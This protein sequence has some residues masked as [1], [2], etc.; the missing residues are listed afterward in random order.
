MTTRPTVSGVDE[1]LDKG[2]SPTKNRKKK[3]LSL[4]EPKNFLG[5]I[6]INDE[7]FADDLILEEWGQE[8]EPATR[9]SS[10]K[11]VFLAVSLNLQESNRDRVSF[12]IQLQTPG[13]QIFT[14]F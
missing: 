5:G 6:C 4:L 7:N 13:L 10:V 8:S 11:K 9:R 14:H 12:L 2:S 1:V 3:H